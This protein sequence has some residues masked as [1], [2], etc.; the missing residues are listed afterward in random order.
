MLTQ[1]HD[2]D[3]TPTGT[4]LEAALLENELIK[5]LCPPYNLQLIPGDPSAWF[6]SA[7]LETAKT[8]PDD[9]HRRGPLPSTFSVRSLGAI[10]A[11]ATGAAPSRAT[12]ACAVGTAERWAPDE[13]VFRDGLGAFADRHRVA[14]PSSLAIVR[15]SLVAAAKRLIVESKSD[16][17]DDVEEVE[18][19]DPWVWDTDRVVRHLER[20]TSHGYQL[21]QRA[22]WLCLLCES[23]VVFRDPPCDR[24]RLFVL[25]EGHIIEA[26][27][28]ASGEPPFEKGPL[29]PFHARRTTFDR[30]KYDRLRTLTT[31]LKRV[32]R[33]GGTAEVRV[34]RNR[35]LRGT[36]L[37]ALLSWV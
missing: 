32:L 7:S 10:Y 19:G 20:A 4:A 3:V 30:H 24:V 25:S 31:E 21:L 37:D 36:A 12:R 11:L 18:A 17:E 35:W 9:V 16:A 8:E 33:D 5:S 2:I 6:F 1:V 22:R 13:S 15:R 14:I 29:R 23:V 26:R 28:V 34:G 27:D